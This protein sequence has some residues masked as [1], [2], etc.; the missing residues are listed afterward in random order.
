MWIFRR[1]LPDLILRMEYQGKVSSWPKLSQL[2]T[3]IL[4][5]MKLLGMALFYSSFLDFAH[6]LFKEEMYYLEKNI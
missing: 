1:R 5:G 2:E 3:D 4:L 6:A